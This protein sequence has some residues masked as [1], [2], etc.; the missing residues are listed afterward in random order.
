MNGSGKQ[1]Q[2]INSLIPRF[3]MCLFEGQIEQLQLTLE[4]TMEKAQPDNQ[5]LVFSERSRL[6]YWFD[7]GVPVGSPFLLRKI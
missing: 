7:N 3:F 2:V 6:M 4:G 1:Y 5:F